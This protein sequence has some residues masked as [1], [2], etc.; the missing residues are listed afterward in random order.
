M[1]ICFGREVLALT[2]DINKHDPTWNIVGFFDDRHEKGEIVNGH[3]VLGKTEELNR[4]STPI[5]MSVS[6]G[7]PKVK[8]NVIDKITNPLVDYPTLIHPLAWIGEKEYVEIGE[9]ATVCAGAVVCQTLPDHCT[10]VGVL[11]TVVKRK[12]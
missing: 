10:A 3:L 11:A 2:K 4:W 8:K 6:I 12:G 1:V 5:S 9:Y 7:D